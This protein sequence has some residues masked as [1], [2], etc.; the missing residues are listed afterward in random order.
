[1]TDREAQEILDEIRT[2]RPRKRVRLALFELRPDGRVDRYRLTA[3][4]KRAI[5]ETTI[6]PATLD[7]YTMPIDAVEWW[8]DR[9]LRRAFGRS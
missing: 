3:S 6:D 7:R 1:M 8:E 2:V 9:T 4:H 5:F